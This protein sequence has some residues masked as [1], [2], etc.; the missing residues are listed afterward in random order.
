MKESRDPSVSSSKSGVRPAVN[1][2]GTFSR[3]AFMMAQTPLAVPTLTCTI[4]AGNL[5]ETTA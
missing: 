2:I 3:A 4:T 1:S 5:P